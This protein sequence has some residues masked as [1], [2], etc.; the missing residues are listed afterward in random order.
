MDTQTRKIYKD[1]E[2]GVR[3][4]MNQGVPRSEAEKRIIEFEKPEGYH[5]EGTTL[6]RDNK[7]FKGP[8][9]DRLYFRYHLKEVITKMVD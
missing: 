9:K 4:L 1:K 7:K 6:V 8:K 2:E 3:D 5:Y